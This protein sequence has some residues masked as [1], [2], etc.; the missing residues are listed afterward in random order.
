MIVD[1]LTAPC[2]V[3]AMPQLSDP[4][5]HRT[6]VLLVEHNDEGSFG[7]VLNRPGRMRVAELC[8]NLEVPWGGDEAAMSLSGGPVGTD[9]GFVLHGA[10]AD[11][12]VVKS[13]L[14]APG[15]Q[16]A[17]DMESFRTLC[18]RPPEEFRMLLGYAGWGPGQLESEIRAGAWLT[19][20]IDGGLVFDTGLDEI[21]ERA[22]RGLGIDPTMLVAGGGVH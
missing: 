20:E 9:Q 19:T 2:L 5:F 10:V 14:V 13:R 12:Q 4:N 1:E 11:D 16:M 15:I 21:W 3:I 6:V 8:A 22:L 18:G 7:L 17:L